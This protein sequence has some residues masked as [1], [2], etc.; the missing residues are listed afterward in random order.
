M[1]LTICNGA[2]LHKKWQARLPNNRTWPGWTRE[3]ILKKHG[4]M[5]IAGMALNADL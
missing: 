5:M 4:Q 2:K 3:S 1:N